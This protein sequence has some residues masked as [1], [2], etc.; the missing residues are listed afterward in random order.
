MKFSRVS[1][2]KNEGPQ[3]GRA[4]VLNS[5]LAFGLTGRTVVEI[6]SVLHGNYVIL[7]GIVDAVALSD[8]FLVNPHGV[9]VLLVR[10]GNGA[11]VTRNFLPLLDN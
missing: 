4:E 6:A 5:L 10:C 7:F 8:D 2:P 9:G 1:S 11:G 3:L